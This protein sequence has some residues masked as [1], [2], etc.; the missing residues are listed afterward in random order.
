MAPSV[1]NAWNACRT[2][3]RLSPVADTI[4]ASVGIRCPSGYLPAAIAARTS[5]ASCRYAALPDPAVAD[6][7]ALDNLASNDCTRAMTMSYLW[8]RPY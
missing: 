3:W 7:L 8:T 5:D 1:A 4:S 2:V 6:S